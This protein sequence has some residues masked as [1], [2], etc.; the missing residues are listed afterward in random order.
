MSGIGRELGS[1]GI[2]AFT[3][4]KHVHVDFAQVPSPEWWFPYERPNIAIPEK[5]EALA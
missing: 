2:S 1:E 4:A 5:M 3:Q